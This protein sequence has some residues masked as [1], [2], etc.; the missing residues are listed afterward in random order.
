ML[1]VAFQMD[2]DVVV[3]R[4]VSV[5]L[6]EEA[7]R[8]GHEVFF[9]RPT[10]LAFA[11]G[12][13]VAEAFSVR[14]GADSLHLHDK[15]R[16]PLGKLDM[17]FVRQ[18]PPFDMRYVTTTYLL[19]RLDILMIN[20]PKAI[21]DHPEKLLPLSFPKFIPPTLITESVSEISAFYAEY[22]DIV[23]KPLYDYGGNGVCRICGRADVGAISSAMVERYEAPLVVQ[24]FIDDIS[25]DK[26]VVLLGDKPIGAVRRKVTAMGEIRTNLR[27]GATP[28]ATELSDRERE[29]CHDV[30]TLLSSVGILFAGIDILGGRLIEVNVTS[31]C[32]ILEINQVYGKTLERD[33]WDHFE[34]VLSHKSP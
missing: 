25:S 8:R 34:Y 27:V 21:R 6:V 18:N 31:P 14:V 26:R 5:K 29:I 20:N 2:E 19:E 3:G 7:Q 32:G 23:L 11:C 17:L 33:C 28:E 24:Q 30:G 10:S 16:L 13:L 12:E 15:T 22:G 4:D 9:Y 1:R